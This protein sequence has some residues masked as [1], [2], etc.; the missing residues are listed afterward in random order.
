MSVKHR[1]E[2]SR[3]ATPERHRQQCEG[4]ETLRRLTLQTDW[5]AHF[6]LSS[7]CRCKPVILKGHKWTETPRCLSGARDGVLLSFVSRLMRRFDSFGQRC[8][9]TWVTEQIWW[10]V[11]LCT[12]WA[13]WCSLSGCTQTN[14]TVSLS[15]SQPPPHPPLCPHP[16]SVFK[17]SSAVC[18]QSTSLSVTSAWREKSV[19]SQPKIYSIFSHFPI[20]FQWRQWF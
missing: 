8:L 12:D 16:P 14:R 9:W 3:A 11:E 1:V 2:W 5:G 6:H 15:V 10:G 4:R 18:A 20:V 17:L 19:R 13:A 7:G